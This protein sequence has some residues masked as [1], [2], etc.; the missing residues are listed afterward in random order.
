MGIRWKRYLIAVIVILGGLVT[1]AFLRTVNKT[2]ME[3]RIRINSDLVHLS[4]YGE[5]PTFAIWIGN[6]E[7]KLANVYVTRRAYENDWEGKPEVPVALPFWY[8]LNESGKF[9]NNNEFTGTDAVSGA[10]PRNEDFAI[11]V[12]VP[13]DSVYTFWI[14]MNLS[15]DYNAQYMDDDP[16][17]RTADEYGNG[18]PALVYRGSIRAVPGQTARA[19]VWGMS[20]RNDTTGQIIHPLKGITTADKVF[21]SIRVAI[22]RPKPYI[23]KTGRF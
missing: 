9:D 22:I 12:A 20:L 7:G 10:T 15:G 6:E 18:Q 17:A 19:E 14:E 5:P 1:F 11:R 16:E 4:A 23:F 13:A 2:E 3:F 21:S 8:S